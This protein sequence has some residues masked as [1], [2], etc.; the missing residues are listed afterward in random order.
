MEGD[1]WHSQD[2]QDAMW[3]DGTYRY[4]TESLTA[5]KFDIARFF[6]YKEIVGALRILDIGAGIGGIFP[7]VYRD[8]RLYI[9]NDLSSVAIEEFKKRTILT[10]VVEFQQC[11]A[12]DLNLEGKNL[13]V[14]LGLGVAKGLFDGPLFRD[15]LRNHLAPGGVL[16]L[17]MNTDEK[18]HF[19]AYLPYPKAVINLDMDDF[20]NVYPAYKRTIMMFKKEAQGHER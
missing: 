9:Y 17:D 20:I 8:T 14:I 4:T 5:V 18:K 13:N 15:L 7:L 6:I 19:A 3:K 2:K 12:K 10:D 16:I 1:V 11:L